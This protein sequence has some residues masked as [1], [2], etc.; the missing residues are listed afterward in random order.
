MAI[1]FAAA[2]VGLILIRYLLVPPTFGKYGHYRA[3]AVDDVAA[4]PIVYAGVEVCRDCHDD[5][6]ELKMN[7]N[8]RGVSCE[9][10]HGP[11]AGHVEAPDE[12]TPDAPRGRTLCP[13]CHDFD[14]ARPT[15]FPQILADRHNP[16]KPCMTCHEPHNPVP[17]HT[18]ED[19]SACHRNI[20]SIKAVSHHADLACVDCHVVAE[21]HRN[22]PLTARA[23][24]PTSRGTCGA[25]HAKSDTSSKDIPRVDIETHGARYLCWDCHYPHFPEAN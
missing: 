9:V 24:K 13:L 19:C 21:N 8:H 12:I 16:G 3:N 14:G 18:P 7:S 10:C 20:A 1:I 17:P 5:I 6:Y 15:G 11:A 23:E 4:L 2:L 25:C 22:D